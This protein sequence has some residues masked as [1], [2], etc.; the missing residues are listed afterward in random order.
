V[1]TALLVELSEAMRT[2]F[3]PLCSHF[4]SPG[5]DNVSKLDL[6]AKVEIICLT[7]RVESMRG[8]GTGARK[9]WLLRSA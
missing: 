5:D 3:S 9:G 2:L 7:F 1:S 6:S 4:G 8:V